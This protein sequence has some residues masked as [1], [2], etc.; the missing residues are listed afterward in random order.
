M[1]ANFPKIS[2][3]TV[4]FN[5]A[6]YLEQTIRSVLDQQ[7]PN[8]EYIIIDGGSNDGSVDIIKKYA[9]HLTYWI[10]EKDDGMYHALQKGFEKS[11]GEIMCWINSDDKFHQGAFKNIAN[12]FTA[13]PEIEWI[14]GMA[15]IFN[16]TGETVYVKPFRKW[17]L[18]D[19]LTVADD[20]IQQ[21]STFWKRS[22]WVRSGS[23]MNL[24]YKLAGDFELWMRFF[25]SSELISI[26]TILGGFRIRNTNQLSFDRAEEYSVEVEKILARSFQKR[27]P[28]VRKQINYWR[29]YKRKKPSLIS[30]KKYI[31][32]KGQ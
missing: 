25:E 30:I 31:E 7:Y 2:V 1:R 27:N 18:L 16:E 13:F 5:Q 28:E 9:E 4:S 17:S 14:T 24:D 21:E 12:I 6:A 15:T 11:T 23:S 26:R 32:N 22:L 29:M 3:V 20:H 8:L 10:S 19:I